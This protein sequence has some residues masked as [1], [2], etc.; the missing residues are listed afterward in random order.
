MFHANH[1]RAGPHIHA[2]AQSLV[3]AAWDV[4]TSRYCVK[5]RW[6]C[7]ISRDIGK[8]IAPASGFRENL[9]AGTVR[10]GVW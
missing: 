2:R 3:T 6:G 9:R 10:A 7:G 8:K 4:K 5:F 1:C